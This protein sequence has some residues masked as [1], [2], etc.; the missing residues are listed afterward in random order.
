MFCALFVTP[1]INV[2]AEYA[3]VMTSTSGASTNAA[4]SRK[5]C[6][7][8][9]AAARLA[10]D[11]D[12]DAQPTNVLLRPERPGSGRRPLSRRPRNP[13]ASGMTLDVGLNSQPLT[14]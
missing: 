11:G 14:R 1:T 8:R 6:I 10:L 13:H 12:D 5:C 7:P 9:A 4:E 3:D 2:T